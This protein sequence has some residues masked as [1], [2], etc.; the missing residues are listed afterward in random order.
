MTREANTRRLGVGESKPFEHE[1]ATVR[2]AVRAH[3]HAERDH[4]CAATGPHID[5]AELQLLRADVLGDMRKNFKSLLVAM[6]RGPVNHMERRAAVNT[7][8][9]ESIQLHDSRL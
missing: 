1:R 6:S 5:M 3:V 9:S 8:K 7:R 2:I 4:E